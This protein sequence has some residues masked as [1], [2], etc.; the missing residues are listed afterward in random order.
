MA[1]LVVLFNLRAGVSAHDYE[2][3]A[4]GTDLPTV[5]ALKS[6][7]QFR[8]LRTKGLLGQNVAAPYQYVET[9]EVNSLDGL[10]ADIGTEQMQA[11]AAQFQQFADNP[12][13][14]H[15]ESIAP[16]N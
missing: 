2:N 1:T 3:W 5:N 4:R 6:V 13:F 16:A 15:C 11:V 12:I 10:F 9:I 8:V 14:I 7:D